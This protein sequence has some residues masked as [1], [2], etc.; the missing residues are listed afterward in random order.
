MT[1]K[2]PKVNSLA[3]TELSIQI[4]T[5]SLKIDKVLELLNKPE[6]S[7]EIQ[8][9]KFDPFNCDEMTPHCVSGGY[10]KCNDKFKEAITSSVSSLMTT[11]EWDEAY[12]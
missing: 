6:P 11:Q 3:Y 12:K 5:L 7:V 9:L 1:D 8:P 10:C 2:K 4:T